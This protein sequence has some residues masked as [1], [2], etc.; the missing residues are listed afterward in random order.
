MPGSTENVNLYDK[1]FY[2]SQAPGS[3]RSAAI[4][5]NHLFKWIQ[6]RSVADVGCGV[7]TWLNVAQKLGATKIVG[8]DGDYVDRS[9]LQIPEESFI[10]TALDH[11][12]PKEKLPEKTE[13]FD[14]VIS[15]EVIEHLPY[16]CGAKFVKGLTQL[17]DTILFGAAAPFQGGTGHVNE[18]WAEYW[19]VHFRREGYIC[20][21]ALRS[22]IWQQ[23]GV[24]WWYAQNSLIFTRRDSIAAQRLPPES[25][26]EGAPLSFVHPMNLLRQVLYNFRTYRAAARGVEEQDYIASANSWRSGETTPPD[27]TAPRLAREA[28]ENTRAAFPTTRMEQSEPETLL[29]DLDCELKGLRTAEQDA[30]RRRADCEVQLATALH[31]M[32]MQQAQLEITTANLLTAR[33]DLE[34]SREEAKADRKRHSHQVEKLIFERKKAEIALAL[35]QGSLIESQLRLNSLHKIINTIHNENEE[36]ALYNSSLLEDIKSKTNDIN[37]LRAFVLKLE[38]EMRKNYRDICEKNQK[39]DELIHLLRVANAQVDAL[40]S[41]LFW[42]ITGPFRKILMRFSGN[43]G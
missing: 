38:D 25:R 28:P 24:D 12:I 19:A 13:P 39:I 27:L 30:Q 33:A 43:R 37:N 6:P 36:I 23:D 34:R 41:S 14:L 8:F 3:A 11:E 16:E 26:R 29:H 17:G 15:M 1:G 31:D 42:R 2:A 40:E 5:L 32:A 22:L 35:A 18:Q 4:I 20:F 7:G 9:A 10:P 21:D